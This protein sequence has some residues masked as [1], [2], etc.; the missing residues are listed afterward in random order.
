M[1]ESE[2][3]MKIYDIGCL[4]SLGEQIQNFSQFSP[5]K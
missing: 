3:T 1:D 5:S 2:E 4:V